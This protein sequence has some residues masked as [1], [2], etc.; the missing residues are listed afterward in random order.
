MT[1]EDIFDCVFD[2]DTILAEIESAI[3]KNNYILAFHKLRSARDTIED[4]RQEDC[5]LDDRDID[6]HVVN[7]LK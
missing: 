2:L 3:L 6:M 5:A 7:V 4:L 1:D